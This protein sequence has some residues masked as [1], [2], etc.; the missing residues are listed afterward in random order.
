MGLEEGLHKHGMRNMSF[1][2]HHFRVSSA[3]VCHY[4][5]YNRRIGQHHASALAA[6]EQINMVSLGMMDWIISSRLHKAKD[7]LDDIHPLQKKHI[8]PHLL[9]CWIKGS[10]WYLCW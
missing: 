8:L 2:S 1:T 6:V 5:E 10:K 7:L 3:S 9:S 4:G